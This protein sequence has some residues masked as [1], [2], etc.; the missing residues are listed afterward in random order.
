MKSVLITGANQGIGLATAKN[1]AHQG[2]YVYLACRNP[3][4]GTLAVD[5]LKAEGIKNASCVQLDVTDQASI[6]LAVK[7]V[8]KHSN[9]LDALINNAGILGN[10]NPDGS[11]SIEEIKRVFE[12]NVY[13]VIRVTRAFLPLLQESDAPRIVHIS[14]GL[15][16]LTNQSDPDWV[17]SHYKSEAYFP[18]KTALNAYCVALAAKLK[19]T[20]CKVNVVDPGFVKTAFNGFQGM[21]D[22]AEA[23]KFITYAATL[24]ENGPTGCFLSESEGSSNGIMPW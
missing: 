1:L 20:R 4:A 7:E 21:H 16:S 6:D 12:T 10:A 11:V 18:S 14:S 9:S 5:I 8:L 24:P 22:P 23:A 13:G 19:S 3:D 15:G 2:Y 17:F